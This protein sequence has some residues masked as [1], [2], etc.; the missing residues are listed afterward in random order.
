ML[1]RKAVCLTSELR[2]LIT[3]LTGWLPMAL[4]LAVPGSRVC[5]G[6]RSTAV[7]PGHAVIQLISIV[8]S[9]VTE[10]CGEVGDAAQ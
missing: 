8:Y 3:A 9:L 10:R 5:P 1:G 4:V 6:F 2:W 7:G